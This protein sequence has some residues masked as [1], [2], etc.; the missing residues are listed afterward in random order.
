MAITYITGVAGSGKSY[1]SVYTTYKMFKNSSAKPT[2]KLVSFKDK[3]LQF[4]KKSVEYSPANFKIKYDYVYTNINQFNFK[5]H[6]LLKPLDFKDL[7]KK[8]NILYDLKINQNYTD[9][10]LII[11]AKKLNLFN[12]KIILDEAQDFLPKKTD[13][14]IRWWL[15][16]HRH[17][18]QDI[19]ILTQH[20]DQLSK[21]Y[22]KNGV[23][24]YKMPPP[25]MAM[26]SNRFTVSYYSC[27]GFTQKCREKSFTIP[28]DKN[29]GDLYVSGDK[30]E[31]KSIFIKFAWIFPVLISAFLYA[32]YYF[33]N[34]IDDEILKN[35]SHV[36]ENKQLSKSL[37]P[38][39][40]NNQTL[41]DEITSGEKED[42]DISKYTF[43]SFHCIDN[44][45]KTSSFKDIP[46]SLVLYI[47]NNM[48]LT[49][50]EHIKVSNSYDIYNTL[51]SEEYMTLLNKSFSN[52][53]SKRGKK[54]SSS[55]MPKVSMF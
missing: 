37:S 19:D 53:N 14:I 32:W 48:E 31:R 6:P 29:V 21:E 46:I 9:D 42:V 18:H 50:S 12:V 23:Y 52:T 25:S 39:Q 54:T 47:F 16:Y 26:F 17:L 2:L 28:F 20:I 5:F 13:E 27:V 35:H 40:N 41:V 55:S 45:C 24:F 43:I 36:K 22:L 11:E 34:Q 7:T 44:K 4:F 10:E 49:Y 51:L 3:K 15:T 30:Q 8:L 33:N 38:G 1:Y